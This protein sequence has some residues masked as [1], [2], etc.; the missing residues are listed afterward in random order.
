MAVL[1]MTIIME[2]SDNESDVSRQDEKTDD[3]KPR[4]I[5]DMFHES[6]MSLS[7]NL[8]FQTRGTQ[9]TLFKSSD[10]HEIFTQVLIVCLLTLSDLQQLIPIS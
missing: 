10:L 8:T 6:G 9:P 2:E 1:L 5:L 7:E 3:K 4:T